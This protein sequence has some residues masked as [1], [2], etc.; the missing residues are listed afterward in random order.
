[1][2]RREWSAE[3]LERADPTIVTTPQHPAAEGN[4]VFSASSAGSDAHS[5]ASTGSPARPVTEYDR[6]LPSLRVSAEFV[7]ATADIAC[8]ANGTPHG[9]DY[10]RRW[11]TIPGPRRTRDDSRSSQSHS[12]VWVSRR[13]GG[14]GTRVF[15]NKVITR[16]IFQARW[17]AVT[18][19]AT[20][21]TTSYNT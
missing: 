11:D 7:C 16:V 8:R 10:E 5:G 19:S 20:T 9:G 17:D 1:M 2:D 4:C 13:E 15:K 21:C 18:P 12:T 6:N 3:Q 14:G